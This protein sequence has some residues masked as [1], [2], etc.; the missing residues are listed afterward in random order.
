MWENNYGKE[1]KEG[2]A[3]HQLTMTTP[4]LKKLIQ[5][6]IVFRFTEEDGTVNGRGIIDQIK[7]EYNIDVTPEQVIEAGESIDN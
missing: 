1:W 3:R 5:C 4:V 6:L 2:K 7:N